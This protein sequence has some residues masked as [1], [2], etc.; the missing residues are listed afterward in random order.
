MLKCKCKCKCICRFKYSKCTSAKCS[1][2][3]MPTVP[4]DARVHRGR[5][6]GWIRRSNGG[7]YSMHCLTVSCSPFYCRF[8]ICGLLVRYS[9]SVFDQVAMGFVTVLKQCRA[10]WRTRTASLRDVS[11]RFVLSSVGCCGVCALEH[12]CVW[13]FVHLCICP[14]EHSSIWALVHLCICAFEHLCICTFEHWFSGSISAPIDF[15][16]GA[17]TLLDILH[18]KWISRQNK[19][20]VRKWPIFFLF[21][22]IG[23]PVLLLP[24]ESICAL[25]VWLWHLAVGSWQLAFGIGYLTFDPWHFDPW[26]VDCKFLL[27]HFF[28]LFLFF[29]KLGRRR[30]LRPSQVR[31]RCRILCRLRCTDW[32]RDHRCKLGQD[33]H[34][35]RWRAGSGGP[36]GPLQ[37]HECTNC[38]M[39]KCT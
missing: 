5:V 38:Q 35:W 33:H 20:S 2:A 9:T 6:E 23:V 36:K 22:A 15:N 31:S 26:L 30:F 12:L 34:H 28:F 29:Q 14:F 4:G 24:T 10:I 27:F 11:L 13:V 19:E 21:E 8:G 32:H 17:S 1:N 39:H 3:Q 37:M 25:R 7:G 18:N 16:L